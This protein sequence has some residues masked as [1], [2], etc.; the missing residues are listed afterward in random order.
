[1]L[2]HV[3]PRHVNGS[4]AVASKISRH[5]WEAQ[6]QTHNLFPSPKSDTQR[7]EWDEPPVVVEVKEKAGTHFSVSCQR[8][9][10]GPI[11]PQTL[12]TLTVS[13]RPGYEGVAS[14]QSIATLSQLAPM[15]LVFRDG[16]RMTRSA[17][18]HLSDQL[19]SRRTVGTLTARWQNGNQRWYRSWS[20]AACVGNR[21]YLGIV[22]MPGNRWQDA[23]PTTPS[24][25]FTITY[26]ERIEIFG[27]PES[28]QEAAQET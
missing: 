4:A 27:L 13:R 6:S 2:N 3:P 28:M 15:R 5:T 19:P 7:L 25:I 24:G 16:H 8:N 11:R 21:R 1:M 22:R 14:A 17:S 9:L 12:A 26:A 18:C 23:A 10:A 20:V